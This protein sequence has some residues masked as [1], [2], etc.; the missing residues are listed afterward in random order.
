MEFR[1]FDRWGETVFASDDPASGWDGRYKGKAVD[2]AVYV[3]WLTATCADGQ[4]YFHKGNVT[5]I[6]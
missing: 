6:R 4:D 1:V 2:P 5:V 3:Y